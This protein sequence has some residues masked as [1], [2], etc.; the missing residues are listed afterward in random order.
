M[1]YL[2]YEKILYEL[3][4]EE[5]V[6]FRDRLNKGGHIYLSGEILNARKCELI[7]TLPHNQDEFQ[8]RYSNPQ[9]TNHSNDYF[10]RV[11]QEYSKDTRRW[12][13]QTPEQKTERNWSCIALTRYLLRNNWQTPNSQRVEMIKKRMTDWFTENNNK[14]WCPV[15]IYEDLL[16]PSEKPKVG[17][18]QKIGELLKV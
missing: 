8:I 7:K 1:M 12:L 4:D 11:N 5:A 6:L 2:K 13:A 18:F 15:E 16:P 10:I 9:I 17:G 14:L 3:T